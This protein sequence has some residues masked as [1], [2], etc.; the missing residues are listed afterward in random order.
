MRKGW[1]LV[2]LGMAAF[3]E[4]SAQTLPS[5]LLPDSARELGRG[6]LGVAEGPDAFEAEHFSAALTFGAW[7][8]SSGGSTLLGFSG[9]WNSGKN[10][11]LGLKAKH[12]RMPSYEII[13]ENG[14]LSQ[15]DGVFTPS[16]SVFAFHAA[17]RPV[18]NWT[19]SASVHLCS[20]SLGKDAKALAVQLDLSGIYRKERFR[21]GL[22]LE[23]LGGKVR[24]APDAVYPQ[25]LRVRA[26]AAYS[27]FEGFDVLAELQWLPSAGLSAGAGVEYGWN[28]SVY[29]RSGVQYGL[30]KA[31]PAPYGTLGLGFSRWGFTLD[32][33]WIFAG[34]T[35]GNTLLFTLA[36]RL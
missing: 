15:I 9:F 4:L 14:T 27:C 13:S 21:A 17:V 20:S 31:A 12:F 34:K 7:Q 18:Q 2:L 1:I 33:A 8:P 32:A 10:L 36:Y 5:L 6:N 25:P 35:L 22:S 16:E 11:A 29:V 19:F 26:G 24:Y 23:N 3:A 30:T 28:R